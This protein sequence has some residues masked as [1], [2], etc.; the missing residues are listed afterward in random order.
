MGDDKDMM[1]M[2]GLRG[3]LRRKE[4][5]LTLSTVLVRELTGGIHEKRKNP[6]QKNN[7]CNKF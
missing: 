6:K 1:G 3:Y 7:Y 2:K 5:T 4:R